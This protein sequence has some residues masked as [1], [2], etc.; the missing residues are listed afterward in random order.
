MLGDSLFAFVHLFID[1]NLAQR[2]LRDVE[3][4]TKS[5][6]EVTVHVDCSPAKGRSI[7]TR[8]GLK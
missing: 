2:D 8:C 3:V 4:T 1:G 6:A 5:T 7:R